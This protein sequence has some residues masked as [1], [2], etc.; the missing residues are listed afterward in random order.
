LLTNKAKDE[1]SIDG[2]NLGRACGHC[3][4]DGG[5]RWGRGR[6]RGLMVM[7]EIGEDKEK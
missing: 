3:K 1:A 4:I 2:Y 7:T 5:G 6:G